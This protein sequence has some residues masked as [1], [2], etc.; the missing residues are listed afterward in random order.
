MGPK[1]FM[2][3]MLSSCLKC[4][5]C[6]YYSSP[7][8]IL[9]PIYR[10][11]ESFNFVLRVSLQVPEVFILQEMFNLLRY[12]LSMRTFFSSYGLCAQFRLAMP[13]ELPYIH[14]F[15]LKDV[16]MWLNLNGLWQKG[17]QRNKDESIWL[18]KYFYI[19]CKEIWNWRYVKFLV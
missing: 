7:R 16:S 11:C 10:Y 3:K 17:P 13:V 15:F 2:S 18:T 1:L 8:P 9:V 12:L 19:C 14:Y 4:D 6:N 5:Y